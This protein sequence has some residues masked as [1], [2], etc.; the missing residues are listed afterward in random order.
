MIGRTVKISML[1]DYYGDLLTN[2]QKEILK[3]YYYQDLSLGEISDNLDI[4]RQAVYDHLHR[5]ENSLKK[6]EKSLN[7]I[8]KNKNNIKLI[9]EISFYLKDSEDIKG[10]DKDILLKK[11]NKIYKNI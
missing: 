2:K 10:E 11:I 3:L 1:F 4:S 8:K 7:L 5:A 9:N 6:Y